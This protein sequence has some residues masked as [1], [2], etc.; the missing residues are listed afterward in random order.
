MIYVANLIKDSLQLPTRQRVKLFRELHCEYIRYVTQDPCPL[1][2]LVEEALEELG[3]KE[4]LRADVLKL[5]QAI[6]DAF[7][8][9][10]V[11]PHNGYGLR[12][13]TRYLPLC[14]VMK[15][16]CRQM[17]LQYGNMHAF[18][19]S[20]VKVLNLPN[21]SLDQQARMLKMAWQNT[22]EGILSKE[23]LLHPETYVAEVLIELKLWKCNQCNTAMTTPLFCGTCLSVIYCS[24]TCQRLGR[25]QHKPNCYS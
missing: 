12:Y 25:H 2:P 19:R 6:I 20:Y 9:H 22:Q 21:G 4:L 24:Q 16:M 1:S 18:M 10:A 3:S 7:P 8:T 13:Q 5:R 11:Y 15:Q 23:M 14:R 17:E